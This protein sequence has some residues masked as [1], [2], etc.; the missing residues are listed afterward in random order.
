MVSLGGVEN[1]GW[2]MIFFWNYCKLNLELGAI[3]AH[4]EKKSFPNFNTY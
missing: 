3:L 2:E 4:Q 1:G